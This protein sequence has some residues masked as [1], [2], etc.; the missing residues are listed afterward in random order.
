MTFTPLKP[1]LHLSHSCKITYRHLL[2][3]DTSLEANFF[4]RKITSFLG[5]TVSLSRFTLYRLTLLK[6]WIFNAIPTNR[7]EPLVYFMLVNFHLNFNCV[8]TYIFQHLYIWCF[9]LLV[10]QQM[11]NDNIRVLFYMSMCL[12]QQLMGR[13]WIFCDYLFIVK[14][15]LSCNDL[16]DKWFWHC[17]PLSFWELPQFLGFTLW[18]KGTI[19]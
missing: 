4:S 7:A 9:C 10:P 19:F 1:P 5:D 8:E 3:V 14:V 15:G 11:I 16:E 13:T 12:C 17:H 6:W 18:R 2:R